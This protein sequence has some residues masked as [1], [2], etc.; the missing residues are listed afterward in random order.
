MWSKI[1]GIRTSLP[2]EIASS[3]TSSPSMNWSIKTGGSDEN[4]KASL[5]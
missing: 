3:S 2:S 1:P 5:I 4:L